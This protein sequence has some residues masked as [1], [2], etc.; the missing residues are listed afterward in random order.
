MFDH[1][2]TMDINMLVSMMNMQLRDL[3]KDF[4]A[5]CIRFDLDEKAVYERLNRAGF[6][7]Q[8]EIRQWRR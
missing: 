8:A 6:L 1:W 3:Q 2:Q 7:Y 4:S 5:F